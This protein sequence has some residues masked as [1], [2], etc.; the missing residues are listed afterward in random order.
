MKKPGRIAFAFLP[1]LLLLSSADYPQNAAYQEAYSKG[2]HELY[3]A[4]HPE[5]ALEFFQ[6]AVQRDASQWAG[7][8]MIGY[9]L[10]QYLKRPEEA[11]PYFQKSL[12]LN[13]QEDPQPYAQM[14]VCMMDLGR[15]DESME[16]NRKAQAAYKAQNKP[17]DDW[18]IENYA[19]AYFKK[20][21]STTAFRIAPMASWLKKWLA[22]KKID[23]RWDI[24]F[25]EALAKWN[26]LD[27]TRVRITLPLDRPYQTM[28]SFRF[29]ASYKQGQRQVTTSRVTAAAGGNRFLEIRRRPSDEWPETIRLT[30]TISQNM[31]SLVPTRPAGLQEAAPGSPEYPYATEDRGGWYGINNPEFQ[32]IVRNAASGGRTTGEKAE[33]A[34]GFLRRHFKYD[35]RI[36]FDN[37]FE[38]YKSGQGDCG[39]FTEIT[40]SFLRIMKV[41]VRFVYGLNAGFNPPLPHAIVEIYDA[42][43]RRWFP[44]DPQTAELY[45]IIDPTY[46]PFSSFSARSYAIET[47]SDGVPEI[48]TMQFFWTGSGN[49]SLAVQI[50][51]QGL[52]SVS[53]RSTDA[54]GPPAF[55]HLPSSQGGA[56]GAR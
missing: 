5:G 32:E 15:I 1:F 50:Q 23:V 55:L 20:G 36:A 41:P 3:E 19:W 28:D 33:L 54:A 9:V 42:S 11:L 51:N 31:N 6:E 48:D 12:T 35:T 25:A 4:N 18:L 10:R 26:M 46:I 8:F 13:T 40:I 27:K 30:I 34:L 56:A 21:D 39:Y 43:N 52:A 37:V 2:I 24:K 53:E 44:H 45:G 47:G 14:A 29:G 16:W 49:D 17:I 38:M 7:H 22:P